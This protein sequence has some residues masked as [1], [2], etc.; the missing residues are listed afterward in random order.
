MHLREVPRTCFGAVDA[1]G[2]TIKGDKVTIVGIKV[3]VKVMDNFNNSC[4]TTCEEFRHFWMRAGVDDRLTGN[5]V[6]EMCLTPDPIFGYGNLTGYSRGAGVTNARATRFMYKERSEWIKR[7]DTQWFRYPIVTSSNSS[8][9][10]PESTM[11]YVQVATTGDGSVSSIPLWTG[12]PALEKQRQYKT[13]DFSRYLPIDTVFKAVRNGTEYNIEGFV[14]QFMV[15]L[16][17]GPNATSPLIE[18]SY[19]LYYKDA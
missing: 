15:F 9:K 17:T 3:N 18:V 19:D 6:N 4:N 11:T 1:D 8:T 12:A 7:W 5:N 14:P 10:A 2:N 16:Y 13:M